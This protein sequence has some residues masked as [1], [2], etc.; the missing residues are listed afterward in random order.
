M[1]VEYGDR[2][3]R[4]G[5]ILRSERFGASKEGYIQIVSSFI[6]ATTLHAN[7]GALTAT[8]PQIWTNDGHA[9]FGGLLAAIG[10]RALDT[11]APEGC[12]LR[13]VSIHH[14]GAV[15]PGPV[16]A[17][18][19]LLDQSR[20]VAS[21]E[22]HLTQED[23]RCV[24]LSAT[25][26][27]PRGR[28]LE[29]P[30]KVPPAPRTPGE[31]DLLPYMEGVMPIFAQLF[32]YKWTEGHLPFSGAPEA[33]FAGWCRHKTDADP[34]AEATVA[35]LDAWPPAVYPLLDGPAQ[36]R[37]LSWTIH[38]TS[39]P[40]WEPGEWLYFRSHATVARDGLATTTGT[41]QHANGAL[42]ATMKQLIAVREPR[43]RR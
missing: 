28:A 34:G 26:V 13:S 41:L 4:H 12:P 39:D 7:N 24:T 21:G 23:R 2:I 11:V 37:T 36:A 9:A 14:H 33:G 38:L 17:H 25:F 22:A 16:E 3:A 15:A 32:E 18:A 6:D 42:L 29:V 19:N 8:I 10:V 31:V 5:I 35:L 1:T 27:R 43:R 40:N 20:L 30:E